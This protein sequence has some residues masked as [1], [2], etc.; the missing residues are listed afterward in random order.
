MNDIQEKLK[1]KRAYEQEEDSDGKRILV[2]RLWPRGIRKENLNLTAWWKDI[3]PSA[4]L[5]K[6]FGHDP[7]RYEG[8]KE[9][10]RQ[11]LDRSDA[12][13]SHLTELA[14]MLEKSSVTLLF[15]AKEKEKNNAA[16]LI[17]WIVQHADA[18]KNQ[19]N[20]ENPVA[21]ADTEPTIKEK[22]PDYLYNPELCPCPRGPKVKCPRY[23]DCGP[24]R[25]FH[26]NNRQT[27]L[28]ACERKWEKERK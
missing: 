13:K 11:E 26:H 18:G 1:I 15:G 8:F 5:R 28:T 4:E 23:K 10:Y 25:E 6:W 17:E 20:S 7:E 22:V 12:M 2:D 3:A 9:K 27:P 24:C 21:A 16:V 14:A 19:R